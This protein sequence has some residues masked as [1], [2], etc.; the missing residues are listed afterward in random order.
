[1]KE[2][3]DYINKVQH[4]PPAPKVL[5]ELMSL[6]GK[7]D[8]DSSRVVDLI[9][10]DPS[11]TASVIQL[12]NSAYFGA[13]TPATD[14]QEAITRLGFQQIFRM[15]AA[16]TASRLMKPKTKGYGI[17]EGELWK[18]S[19]TAAVAAQLMAREL[20]DDENE[21]FTAALLH[22]I[23]KIILAQGLE[24]IYTALIEEIEKNQQ[25]LIEAEKKLLGVQHAEIGGRLLARWKFPSNM[26]AAIWFHHQPSMAA[27]HERLASYIY[28]GNMVAYFIGHGFGH[29]A[30]AL[31]GRS[32]ALEVLELTGDHLPHFM[33]QTY[34][35]YEAVEALFHLGK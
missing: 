24:N 27:P 13:A 31:R 15:V 4:L 34:E 30:F 7:E 33:I 5:P 1:M 16:V 10:Y 14:L 28:L 2:L 35:N 8:V 18:H 20:G 23:G 9:T 22:D 26:V 21:V 12:C 32:E 25:A 19:V 17:H 29:Q 6:L 11:L 3:D